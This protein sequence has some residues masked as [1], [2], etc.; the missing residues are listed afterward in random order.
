VRFTSIST[1]PARSARSKEPDVDGRSERLF[2]VVGQRQTRRSPRWLA[3]WPGQ[4]VVTACRAKL[5]PGALGNKCNQSWG[6][7]TQ[8]GEG[9]LSGS[10]LKGAVALS[11]PETWQRRVGCLVVWS[12][13]QGKLGR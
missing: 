5:R 12:D 9:E 8:P 3:S 7:V 13:G 4:L 2:A 6:L 10:G 1:A 11:R